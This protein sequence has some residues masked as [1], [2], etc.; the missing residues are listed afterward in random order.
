MLWEDVDPAERLASRFGFESSLVAADWLAGVLDDSWG[1]ANSTCDRLLLSD[2]NVMAWVDVGDRTLVAKWSVHRPR[3]QR[4]ADAAHVT[5]WLDSRSV[6][7]AAPV[8]ARDGSLLVD[9]DDQSTPILV[10]VFPAV[11]G[12]L[13][14]VGDSSQVADAG[15]MLALL[16]RELRAYDAPFS[17]GAPAE[18]EQ[19][20]HNDFR[21]ANILHDGLKIT[22]VLDLE[23][24]TYATRVADLAKSAVFLGTQYRDWQPTSPRARQDFLAAYEAHEP[25]SPREHDELA[26]HTSSLLTSMGWA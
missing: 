1:F 7:V 11:Q 12:V 10:G 9:I 8:R 23:E 16:H 22:G 3:F 26:G 17:S 4:L 6:P 14:D 24:M 19:L 25:L 18:G 5:A 15:E 21:S 2:W 13:L 20:V